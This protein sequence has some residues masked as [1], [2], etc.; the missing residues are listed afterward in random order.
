MRY[1][2]VTKSRW[3]TIHWEIEAPDAEAAEKVAEILRQREQKLHSADVKA[4]VAPKF[5]VV[6]VDPEGDVKVRVLGSQ[7]LV[8]GNV[9]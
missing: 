3:S 2:V 1:N 9:R 6:W 5:P 7:H 4:S 8:I